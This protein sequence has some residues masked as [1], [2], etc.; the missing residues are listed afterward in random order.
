MF[1]RDTASAYLS[2]PGKDTSTPTPNAVATA[3]LIGSP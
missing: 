1:A 3:F 2:V